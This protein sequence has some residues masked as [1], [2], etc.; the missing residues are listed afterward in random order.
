MTILRYFQHCSSSLKP[1]NVLRQLQT[2]AKD[3]IRIDSLETEICLHIELKDGEGSV[4]VWCARI[5]KFD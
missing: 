1:A 4:A 3:N 5:S 2:A